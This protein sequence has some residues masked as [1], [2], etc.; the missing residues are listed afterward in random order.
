VESFSLVALEAAALGRPVVGFSGARGLTG[1][2]GGEPGLLVPEFDPAAMAT[3]IYGLLREPPAALAVGRRL[4]RRV[5]AEFLAGPNLRLV[6]A[7]A[8]RLQ[9]KEINQA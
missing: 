6:L 2:L 8:E 7:A 9:K 3:V 1:V 4:R 5:E